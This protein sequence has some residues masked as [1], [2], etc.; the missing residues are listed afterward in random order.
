MVLDGMDWL[1]AAFWS[2]ESFALE[3]VA[4]ALLGRGKHDLSG[5]AGGDSDSHDKVGEIN[6]LYREDRA[7][8][9][10][11]NIEDC[12]LVTEIFARAGLVEFALRRAELTGLAMDRLGGSVAAF[13]NLY[14]P[15]LHRRGRVAPDV[16]RKSVV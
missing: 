1:R 13:D 2:F 4:R 16:D 15:R 10:A 14:L 11:Y 5:D 9:A 6:R 7:R 12:R 3:S 8:L